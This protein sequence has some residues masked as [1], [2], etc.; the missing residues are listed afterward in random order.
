MATATAECGDFNDLS[1]AQFPYNQTFYSLAGEH[2]SHATNSAPNLMLESSALSETMTRS[3][4]N[5]V[6]CDGFDVFSMDNMSKP[7]SSFAKT[8]DTCQTPPSSFPTMVPQYDGVSFPGSPLPLSF[9]SEMKPSLLYESD[10]SSPLSSLQ[11]SPRLQ[12]GSNVGRVLAPKVEPQD[13]SPPAFPPV[14]LVEVKAEDGTVK[15]KAE[16]AR[17]APKPQERKTMFCKYCDDHPN[18]FHGV[19]ELDRH[20]DR[21]HTVRRKVWICKEKDPSENFLSNCKACRNKKTYGANYNAAAHLRRAHFHPP[22]NKRGGRSKKSE[23]RGGMGGGNH[24]PMDVLKDYMYET[25]EI[26]IKGR[27]DTSEPTTE[28]QMMGTYSPPLNDY[29]ISEQFLP[30]YG[31]Q[32]MM[33]PQSHHQFNYAAMHTTGTAHRSLPPAYHPQYTTAY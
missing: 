1:G 19:H 6:L 22:K 2:V 32:S 15:Q 10:D 21:H 5:D 16:I 12:E 11:S 9:S 27:I 26:N 17:A 28:E 20:I 7:E 24:P 31:H 3:N 25:W 8:E 13:S 18:G 4:T 33:V 23:N 29:A 30:T 14:R